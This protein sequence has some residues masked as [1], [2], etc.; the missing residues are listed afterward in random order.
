MYMKD[1]EIR[2]FKQ[3]DIPLL[4]L[5]QPEGWNRIE[6][7]FEF[8]LKNRVCT[9][10]IAF[11]EDRPVG[12]ACSINNGDTGW[13]A[14]II[15]PE[16]DKR[17]GFGSLLTRHA[18]D[19]LSENGCNSLSLI[20][21]EEGALLYRTLGFKPDGIYHHFQG[22][23]TGYRP[24]DGNG[25]RKIVAADRDSILALDRAISG[26]NREN[27]LEEYLSRGWLIEKPLTGELTGFFL[28]ELSEGTIIA[29]N[30]QSGLELLAVKHGTKDCRSSLP[31]ANGPGMAFLQKAGFKRYNSSLRMIHGD[32]VTWEPTGVF[33][34][35]GGCY[36]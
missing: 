4:H 21:T 1:P 17:K 31:E 13:L 22:K 28:S 26:E 9:P 34:R 8:Y 6:G 5:F 24:D 35:I 23:K 19:Y 7:A 2:L 25:V 27:V 20:A 29:S 12:I 14:H 3:E 36:A 18:M 30:P 10:F 32:R 33:S 16:Q 15:V 11:Q